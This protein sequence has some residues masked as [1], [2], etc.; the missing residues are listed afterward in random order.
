MNKYQRAIYRAFN[1]DLSDLK[2]EDLDSHFNVS[3]HE[4]RIFGETNGDVELLSMRWLRGDGLEIGAGR[5]PTPL[6][7][8]ASAVY[9]DCDEELVFG[10][11]RLDIG[12]SLDD[13][14]F[15]ETLPQNFD[16]I[17]ASH[18]LEHV[19]SFIRAVHNLVSSV[20]PGGIIYIVLPDKEFLNDKNF[21]PDYSFEHHELEF[22]NP[23]LFAKVHD[24]LFIGAN[25]SGIDENNMHADLSEEYKSQIKSGK[26]SENNRFLHH[27]H[28]Y[29]YIGWVDLILQTKKYLKN[30]FDILDMRYGHARRDCH[31]I[32]RSF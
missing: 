5:Y 20:R 15:S 23:L 8:N 24:D 3:Q 1:A 26:I 17:I 13:L 18:V 31:F 29:S 2:D 9:G 10:G 27:K 11:G 16:F 28:N 32:L 25:I 30:S 12:I 19:D 14:R 21:I 4:R 6:F 22:T 7:G